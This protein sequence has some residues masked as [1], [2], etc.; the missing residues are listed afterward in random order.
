MN[1]NNAFSL[2]WG[3]AIGYAFPMGATWFEWTAETTH[4][5]AARYWK[6]RVL[7]FHLGRLV[8]VPKQKPPDVVRICTTVRVGAS[9]VSY[10]PDHPEGEDYA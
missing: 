3:Y 6:I 10:E 8:A 5:I 2:P 9:G 7:W 4:I 1:R